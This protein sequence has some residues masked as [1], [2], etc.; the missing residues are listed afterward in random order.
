MRGLE[1][2]GDFQSIC[3]SDVVRDGTKVTHS[4]A[5]NVN[6]FGWPWTVERVWL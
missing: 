6:D 2:I 4:I 5:T 3:I 1:K